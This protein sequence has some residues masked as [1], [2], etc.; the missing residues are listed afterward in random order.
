MI[1][2]VYTTLQGIIYNDFPQNSLHQ[3]IVFDK[4]ILGWYYGDRSIIAETPGIVFQSASSP[5]KDI[6]FGTRLIEHQIKISCWIRADSNKLV[7]Q[8]TLEF[9]RLVHEAL[10]PHRRIW[11]LTK[12]P[13]CPLSHGILTKW[14]L[15]PQHF[16]LGHSGILGKFSDAYSGYSTD[17]YVAKAKSGM[18]AIWGQ[19]HT[20]G[21]S[22][23]TNSRL[24]VAAFNLLYE[25]VRLN[26]APVSISGTTETVLKRYQT[27]KVRP[28]RLLYDCVFTDIKPCQESNDKGL[29]RGGEFT[30]SAKELI[31]V[32]NFGPD[33][34]PTD[35]WG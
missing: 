29:F 4:P 11:V 17:S 21:Y 9:T 31:K 34:I 14:S 12:C 3:A 2:D 19:T 1:S 10:L 33:N 15:S 18:D 30:L 25:D 7:E 22:G 28:I 23:Y 20:T 8:Q 13:L 6:A 26:Q 24:S 35:V 5:P 27:N 32:S 16:V